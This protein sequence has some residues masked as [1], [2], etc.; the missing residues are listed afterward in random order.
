MPRKIVVKKEITISEAKNLLERINEL[1][2]LQLRTFEYAKKFSK[3]DPQK[4]EEIVNALMD[5]FK[6]ERDDAVQVVNCMPQSIQELRSFFST[7]AKKIILTSQLEE[8]L[9]I[10]D[11]YR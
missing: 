7:G 9:K 11:Q 3:I 2:Q 5:K 8:I 6:I 4:A 10:L 1:N